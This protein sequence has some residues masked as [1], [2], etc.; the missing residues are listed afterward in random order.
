[1]CVCVCEVE[2]VCVCVCVCEQHVYDNA[3]AHY[4]CDTQARALSQ[5][6]SA[7]AVESVLLATEGGLDNAPRLPL[8]HRWEARSRKE[9]RL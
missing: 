3:C 2:I 4:G 8:G 1:M 6:P 9:V 5:V 7:S